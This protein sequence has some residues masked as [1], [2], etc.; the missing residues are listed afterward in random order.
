MY[1]LPIQMASPFKYVGL[2][3]KDESWVRFAKIYGVELATREMLSLLTKVRLELI[4]LPGLLL[5]ILS[6]RWVHF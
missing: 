2:G 4:Y 5:R 1:D 3:L 6:V